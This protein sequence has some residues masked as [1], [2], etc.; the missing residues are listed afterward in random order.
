M[1]HSERREGQA[2]GRMSLRR[3]LFDRAKC[4]TG[5]GT[6]A[7]LYLAQQ[8]LWPAR[9]DLLGEGDSAVRETREPDESLGVLS[10]DE[11]REL[12]DILTKLGA[13]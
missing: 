2:I 11:R 6:R 7:A 9:D 13:A 8:L 10:Q 1:Q 5:A 12:S 4:P 3:L